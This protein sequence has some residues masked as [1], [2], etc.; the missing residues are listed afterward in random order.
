[1]FNRN[2]PNGEWPLVVGIAAE[3]FSIILAG[4]YYDTGAVSAQE[5]PEESECSHS[6]SS[7]NLSIVLFK[8]RLGGHDNNLP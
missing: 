8:N 1:M 6:L 7:G 4:M 2:Q 3:K 5:E